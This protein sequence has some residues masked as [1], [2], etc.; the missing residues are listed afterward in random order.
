MKA[1]MIDNRLFP[2]TNCPV[3][4]KRVIRTH[5]EG[6]W[7]NVFVANHRSGGINAD[8]RPELHPEARQ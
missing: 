2:E 4:T 6:Q 1:F 7:I 8:M 5:R 3:S